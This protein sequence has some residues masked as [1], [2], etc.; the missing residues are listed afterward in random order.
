LESCSTSIAG[1]VTDFVTMALLTVNTFLPFIYIMYDSLR[2]FNVLTLL[3]VPHHFS[4]MGLHV[5]KLNVLLQLLVI[6]R[7]YRHLSTLNR[8]KDRFTKINSLHQAYQDCLKLL[9]ELYGI[10][11]LL[12]CLDDFLKIL[13]TTYIMVL[14]GILVVNET[15]F[16]TISWWTMATVVTPAMELII[17]CHTS[18][19]VMSKVRF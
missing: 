8:T 11:L 18:S 19:S 1:N 5:V 13:R 17:I 4:Q 15:F 9:R 10:P 3:S 14:N 2:E 7:R 6:N 12:I 16:S